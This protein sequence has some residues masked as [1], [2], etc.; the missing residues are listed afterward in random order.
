MDE[1]RD[2]ALR[3]AHEAESP[4]QRKRRLAA[5]AADTSREARVRRLISEANQLCQREF[6]VRARWEPSFDDKSV[7]TV[8]EGVKV[9]YRGNGRLS[10]TLASLGKEIEYRGTRTCPRCGRF[11][12]DSYLDSHLDRHCSKPPLSKRIM[13]ILRAIFPETLGG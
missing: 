13:R 11:L 5:A 10:H 6:G 12:Y 2:R 4:A 1:L 8:I 9:E 3:A 7:H